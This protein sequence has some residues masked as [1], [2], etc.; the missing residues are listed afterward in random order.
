[1]EKIR[2]ELDSISLKTY[3]LEKLMMLLEDYFYTHHG[4]DEFNKHQ[5]L[6]TTIVEKVKELD[7]SIIKFYDLVLERSNN[8]EK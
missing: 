4:D 2:E 3:S 1:M 8:H 5:I 6:S 7:E